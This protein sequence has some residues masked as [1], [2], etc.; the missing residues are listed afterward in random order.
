MEAFAK[1]TLFDTTAT[2]TAMDF[3]KEHSIEHNHLSKLI[4]DKINKATLSMKKEIDKLRETSRNNSRGSATTTQKPRKKTIDKTNKTTSKKKS[5]QNA[6]LKKKKP[7]SQNQKT[8]HP[9]KSKADATD[10]NTS[11]DNK[12][13]I[14]K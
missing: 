4:N 1:M 10:S 8:V 6:S 12:K 13:S 11:T 9:N 14:K 5:E 3:V 7:I 2:L